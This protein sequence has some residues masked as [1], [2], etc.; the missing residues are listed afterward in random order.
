[1]TVVAGDATGKW[2]GTITPDGADRS[3]PAYMIFAQDGNKLSGSGGPDEA[4][5]HPF[6]DGK[7]QGDRMIFEV[8]T[9]KGT[10]S[11]DLKIVGDEIKGEVQA[12]KDGETRT[13]R[14]SLKRAGS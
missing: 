4:E 14:I 10:L 8:S 13:A 5:R 3:E 12:K 6:Q 11:F 7:V 2:T 9:P 1:M